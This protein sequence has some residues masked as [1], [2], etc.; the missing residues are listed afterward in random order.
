MMVFLRAPPARSRRAPRALASSGQARRTRR[1]SRRRSAVIGEDKHPREAARG[2]CRRCVATHRLERDAAAEAEARALMA[3]IRAAG[4]LDFDRE[5]PDPR[6][7]VETMYEPGGGKMLGVLLAERAETSPGSTRNSTLDATREASRATSTKASNAT[8]TKE[9]VVLKAFSGQMRGEWRVPGWAPPLCALTHDAPRYAEAHEKIAAATAAARA[10]SAEVAEME[11]RLLDAREPWD[12]RIREAAET[13]K[14]ARRA[15]RARRRAFSAQ[16]ARNA[17][18]AQNAPTSARRLAFETQLAEESRADKREMARLRE[19]RAAATAPLE[20]ALAAARED[21]R[22][23]RDAHRSMSASLLAEIFDSYRLPNFREAFGFGDRLRKR[24]DTTGETQLA[25]LEGLESLESLEG[26]EGLEGL[27]TRAREA[28]GATLAEC[29]V[30]DEAAAA[31]AAEVSAEVSAARASL[32]CGCGDCCAPKLLAEC[33]LRGLKPLSIAEVWMGVS[34][35][36]E[37]DREEGEFYGACRGRCRPILGHMLCGADALNPRT[38]EKLGG[39]I[40]L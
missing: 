2:F 5:V 33:A 16:N 39:P 10:R 11:A 14:E 20:S 1:E 6:F 37:G 13:A 18:N 9:I 30:A 34:T 40:V 3:R 27:E 7:G 36:E 29:F 21:A 38:K 26:L 4:R 23:L 22:G 19:A 24:A 31:R 15:R 8:K 17:Q 32:P 28:P 25:G 12:A 35:R